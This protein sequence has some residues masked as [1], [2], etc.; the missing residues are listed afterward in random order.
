MKGPIKSKKRNR[1]EM[2]VT[3][4]LGQPLGRPRRRVR[5]ERC[6]FRNWA[7]TAPEGR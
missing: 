7:G 3:V 2:D 5:C 4:G 6:G 1:S